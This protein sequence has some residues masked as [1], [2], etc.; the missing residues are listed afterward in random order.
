MTRLNIYFK[1][2]ELPIYYNATQIMNYDELSAVEHII[3]RHKDEFADNIN[4][5]KLFSE[6]SLDEKY[7]KRN[8]TFN[9]IYDIPYPNIGENI[10]TL[11]VITLPNSKD[12][13]T[14]YPLYNEAERL[15]EQEFT[16]KRRK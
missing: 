5:Y 3:E 9:N 6:V 15:D 8:I 13:L 4:L 10:D 14:M 7:H 16:L 11:R 12:I 2:I 1:D